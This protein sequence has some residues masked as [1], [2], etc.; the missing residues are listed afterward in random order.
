MHRSL[1]LAGNEHGSKLSALHLRRPLAGRRH[2]DGELG[3]PPALVDGEGTRE[4]ESRFW[5]IV[6][7]H[8]QPGEPRGLLT[9]WWLWEQLARRLWPSQPAPGEPFGLVKIRVV[10]YHGEAVDL[11]DGTRVEPGSRIA[12][13]HC[14]NERALALAQSGT[15]LFTAAR[16][17]LRALANWVADGAVNI[18]A[19]YGFTML[20]PAAAR[21]GFC[22]RVHALTPRAVADRLYMNG[23]LAIYTPEGLS[24]LRQ[25]HVL[26]AA[27]EEVWMS[28]GQLLRLYRDSTSRKARE[29]VSLAPRAEEPVE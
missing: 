3:A 14:D 28:R 20:G 8:S 21:L 6:A 16:D 15:N 13:I 11:P 27:P 9:G 5:K 17:D 23:L 2:R 1:S 12:E 18:V 4:W 22:R 26:E 7:S 24:R 19:L 25:G 10:A 29:G